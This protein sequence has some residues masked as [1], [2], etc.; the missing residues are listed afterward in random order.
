MKVPLKFLLVDA[1][2]MWNEGE[3]PFQQGA[4]WGSGLEEGGQVHD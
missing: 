3:P 4:L 1:R 2:V